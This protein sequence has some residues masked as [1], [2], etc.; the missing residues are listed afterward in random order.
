MSRRNPL[1]RR[2][3]SCLNPGVPSVPGPEELSAP[4][5]GAPAWGSLGSPR[6]VCPGR[7]SL[8][9]WWKPGPGHGARARGACAAMLVRAAG[10][11]D[12][13][14]QREGGLCV[15]CASVT[16][17][18]CSLHS[19]TYAATPARGEVPKNFAYPLVNYPF[20]H[21]RLT[22]LLKPGA[23]SSLV[24]RFRPRLEGALTSGKP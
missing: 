7:R 5:P 10:P 11:L 6:R 12:A 17:P 14:A 24:F 15:C 2:E 13:C 21:P 20:R 22:Y 9:L 16:V 3:S 19:L 18:V 23:G 8:R 4:P 1:G